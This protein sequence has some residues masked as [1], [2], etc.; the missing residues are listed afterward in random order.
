MVGI[1]GAGK[2]TLARRLAT[3]SDVPLL[4]LDAV[5]HLPG[6]EPIG[7]EAFRAEVG[8]FVEQERWVVDGNYGAVVPD[9]VWGR[10]DVVVWLDLPRR[11]VVRRVT[12]RS[13][14]RVLRREELWNGNRET[15]RSV[16]SPDPKRSVVRWAWVGHGPLRERYE[17]AMAEAGERADGPRWVRLRSPADVDRYLADVA[18]G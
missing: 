17:A 7:A 13:I 1:S 15:L 18:L 8:R 4:E 9:L 11:T 14:G 6:W 12:W 10:A 16:L 2:S 5:H 3:R